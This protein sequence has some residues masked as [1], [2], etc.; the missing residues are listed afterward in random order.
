MVSFSICTGK[1][2]NWIYLQP[3]RLMQKWEFL[4]KDF[5]K[6]S[7]QKQFGEKYCVIYLGFWN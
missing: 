1:L 4:K 7:G 5:I 2:Y 6:N 3:L